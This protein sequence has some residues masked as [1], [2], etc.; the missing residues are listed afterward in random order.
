M[1]SAWPREGCVGTVQ[2]SQWQIAHG[3]LPVRGKRC[4]ETGSAGLRGGSAGMTP[5]VIIYIMIMI[6]VMN[7]KWVRPGSGTAQWRQFENIAILNNKDNECN[8][9]NKCN[10]CNNCNK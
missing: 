1:G 9:Y 6:N 8:G 3:G 4:P 2:G 10:N 7:D 5:N